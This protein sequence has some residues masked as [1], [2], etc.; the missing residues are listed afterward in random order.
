M[1][2]HKSVLLEEAHTMNMRESSHQWMMCDR[3]TANSVLQL[4]R[5]ANRMYESEETSKTIWS[6]FLKLRFHS[7]EPIKSAIMAP[8]QTTFLHSK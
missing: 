7:R 1:A 5:I 8:I 2:W 6:V 3:G 4:G